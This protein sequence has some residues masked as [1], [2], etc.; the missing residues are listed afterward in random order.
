MC[1]AIPSKIV[2]IEGAVATAE[3]GGSRVS[4]RLDLVEGAK[5][6]DYVLVHAGFAITLLD[7][8]DARETLSLMKEAGIV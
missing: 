7:P 5:L 4:A 2:E 6:G 1:L 8:E 3:V